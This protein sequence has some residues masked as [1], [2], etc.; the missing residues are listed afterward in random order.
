MDKRA[1]RE[2]RYKVFNEKINSFRDHPKYAELRK[3]ADNAMVANEGGGFTMI[4]AADFIQRIEENPIENI[5][6]WLDGEKPLYHRD[7]PEYTEE[8]GEV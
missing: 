7:H 8:G 1:W 5:R 2:N 3:S 4:T 6:K